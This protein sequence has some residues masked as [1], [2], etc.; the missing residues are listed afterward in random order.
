VEVGVTTMDDRPIKALMIEQDLKYAWRLREMLSQVP[1]ALF[2]L[3]CAS[4]LSAGLDRLEM[5]G[6]DVVLL[7]LSPQNA[8]GFDALTQ[9]QAQAPDVPL[10]VIGLHD[11]QALAMKTIRHGVQDYIVRGRVDGTQLA[12]SMRYAIERKRM[13]TVLAQ[14]YHEVGLLNRAIQAFNSSLDLDH[15]LATV[16]EE[17][18]H[19]LQVVACSIWL[20]EPGTGDLV[21]RQATGQ[22]GDVV[23]GWRLSPGEGIAGL[24][25][26]EGQSLI[27][28]D[29]VVDERHFGGLDQLTGLELRSILTVPLQVRNKVIG[30]LQVLDSKPDRFS[31]ADLTLLEPLALAAAAA[32]ENARLYEE[33][34]R[35]RA[36]NEK[37]VQGMEE[38]VLLDDVTGRITFV[39]A[40]AAKMLGYTPEEL[41][42]QHRMVVLAPEC[43]V[44]IEEES[45]KWAKGGSS[46]Y[47]AELLTKEGQR[48]PV[49]VS[50]RPMFN[51]GRFAGVLSVLID[52]NGHK[53]AS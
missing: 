5:G 48:V 19:L 53:P 18:R 52:L 6:I 34:E 2:H 28:P 27:V 11:D 49:V 25:A 13:E 15:V 47:E 7:S 23:Q 8:L 10:I 1:G 24:V 26:I 9:V 22:K 45:A 39:N 17:T 4:Q 50:A 44:A 41:E 16:L 42:G 21:C 36:F 51:D 31:T 37:I 38:G 20:V 40:R 33:T 35:L 14:Q 12:C 3:E 30:V 43:M 29:A 46:R 32:L